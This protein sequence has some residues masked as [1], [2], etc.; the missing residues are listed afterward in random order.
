MPEPKF[1][2]QHRLCPGCPAGV[3]ASTALEVIPEPVVV[4][5]ATGC[6]E[7]GTTIYPNSAWQVPTLHSAFGNS[8]ATASGIARAKKILLAK[9]KQHPE[10][11]RLHPY[12]S[13][14][15]KIV[16]FAGDGGTYDIGL[17]ALSGMAERGED[18]LYICYNNQAYMN[19]GVQRSSATPLGAITSTTPEV[20][21]KEFPKRMTEIM[22]AHHIPYV[23]QTAYGFFED[24]KQKVKEALQIKGPK[25]IEVLSPCIA[26]WHIEPKDTVKIAQLIVETG[27][28]PLFTYKKGEFK[29]TYQPKFLRVEEWLREDPRFRPLLKDK[30]RVKA[31][32]KKIEEDWRRWQKNEG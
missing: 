2:P 20:G 12:L 26:G 11:R 6:L 18:V 5:L 1:L 19:T 3:I 10:I 30:K 31:L 27:Y 29:L 24:L 22:I 16:V 28:W 15:L 23:A 14:D 13:E 25:Y 4:V 8:A 9:E 17:Q 32:Q 7:V 21:K